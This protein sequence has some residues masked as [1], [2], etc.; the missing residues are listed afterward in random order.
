MNRWSWCRLDES[1]IC[2]YRSINI[3]MNKAPDKLMSV[4]R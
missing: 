3:D 1:L 2:W 4:I